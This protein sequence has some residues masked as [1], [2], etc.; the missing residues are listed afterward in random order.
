MIRLDVST[1]N[2]NCQLT[3]TVEE[4][5][6]E[7]TGPLR[8]KFHQGVCPD[9]LRTLAQTAQ[10]L[11][12]PATGLET[13]KSQRLKETGQ[14]LFHLLFPSEV[15]QKLAKAASLNLDL[16]I[17]DALVWIPWE[18]LHDGEEFLCLQFNRKFGSAAYPSIHL[19]SI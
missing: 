15:K 11:L 6:A 19:A 2:N 1:S 5:I 14:H 18:I 10:S 12:Y 9:Q 17:D 7:G 8:Q 3:I 16:V 4:T 13:G